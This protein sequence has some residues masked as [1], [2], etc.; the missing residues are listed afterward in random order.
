MH[1]EILTPEQRIYSG[2]V[3]SVSLPGSEGS[4]QVLRNHAP[5][6]AALK[7]GTVRYAA[8]G[9]EYRVQISGGLVEVLKNRVTVLAE[10]A[11][12]VLH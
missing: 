6:I 10:S 7:A 3:T 2:E 1:L 12:E 8:S 9:K 11:A 5:L 4:F